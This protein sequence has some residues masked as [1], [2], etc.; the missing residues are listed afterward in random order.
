MQ[1]NAIKSENK[2]STVAEMGDRLGPQ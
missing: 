1:F 2:R